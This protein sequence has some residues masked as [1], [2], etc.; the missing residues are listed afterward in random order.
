MKWK[1]HIRITLGIARKLGIRN[2]EE[3]KKGV[4]LPDRQGK[5]DIYY[6]LETDI[7]YP[8]H[9]GT[10]G[11]IETLISNIRKKKLKTGV[12]DYLAIGAL[13]HLVQDSEALPAKDIEHK[14]YS[15]QID[16]VDI[17]YKLKKT[18]FGSP[19][20]W[21]LEQ[22]KLKWLS[23]RYGSQPNDSLFYSYMKTEQVL[24]SI[25]KPDKFPKG[26][27][28]LKLHDEIH[29][30][31]FRRISYSL[32]TYIPPLGIFNAIMDRK[33]I[34]QNDLVKRYIIAKKNSIKKILI[35]SI[36]FVMFLVLLKFTDI[37][38]GVDIPYFT[39]IIILLI[40]LPLLGQII[41]HS[42]SIDEEMERRV[43]WFKFPDE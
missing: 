29:D 30:S 33:G 39:T 2:L 15:D 31:K 17:S 32:L 14:V 10:Q 13:C 9:Y 21:L 36:S 19:N 28:Y 12:F 16:N 26:K 22:N 1:S 11:R 7:S 23:R 25:F 38:S 3:L 34:F 37:L 24:R 42:F 35:S 6:L 27:K 43:D 5:M 40:L 4:I 20:G 8:H 41:P 18:N